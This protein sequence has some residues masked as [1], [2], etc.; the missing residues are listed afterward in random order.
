MSEC[1]YDVLERSY[2]LNHGKAP[3]GRF[4]DAFLETI[5]K[6]FAPFLVTGSAR[7]NRI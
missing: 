6:A 1:N 3:I 2:Y 5:R 7:V 4:S